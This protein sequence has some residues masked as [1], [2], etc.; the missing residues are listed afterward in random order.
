MKINFDGKRKIIA[1]TFV[2]AAVFVTLLITDMKRRIGYNKALG[3]YREM[4][5]LSKEYMEMKSG[6]RGVEKRIG[7]AKSE[8]ISIVVEN[9]MSG[10]G[11]REKLES[12]KPFGGETKEDYSIYEAEV[13]IDNVTLNELVN[14]LYAVYTVPAGLFVTSAEFK[15]DFSEK[16]LIDA[17]VSLKLVGLTKEDGR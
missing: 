1:V 12:V 11:L 5:A 17:M 4:V 6:I 16:T 2:L 8:N 10:I 9:L 3:Q 15:T 7:L 14:I 13:M